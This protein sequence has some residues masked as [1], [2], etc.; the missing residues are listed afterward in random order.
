MEKGIAELAESVSGLKTELAAIKQDMTELV[1]VLVEINDL[2]QDT[3][4]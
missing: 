4:N 3:L 1:S 2:L